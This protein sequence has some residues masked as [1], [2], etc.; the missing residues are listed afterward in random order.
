MRTLTFALLFWYSFA[1]P[2]APVTSAEGQTSGL[3]AMMG[4]LPRIYIYPNS[5]VFRNASAGYVNMYR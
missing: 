4:R 5:E 2:G 1:A 3:A